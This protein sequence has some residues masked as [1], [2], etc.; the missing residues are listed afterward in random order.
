MYHFSKTLCV[1][2][3]EAIALVTDALKAEALR[4]LTEIDVQSACKKKLDIDFRRY[5]I[6]Y[7][8][9]SAHVEA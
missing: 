3:E 1:S 2:Y 6:L 7:V 8:R 4:I 9:L 5:K